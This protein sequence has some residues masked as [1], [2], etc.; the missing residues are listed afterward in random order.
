MEIRTLPLKYKDRKLL[1]ETCV[2]GIKADFLV[3][4]GANASLLPYDIA[5]DAGLL[6][7]LE[8]LPGVC[9]HNVVS[10]YSPTI[11]GRVREP[12]QCQFGL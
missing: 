2:A 3:D 1:L 7:Q 11:H 6:E 8:P 4:T 5:K 12:L 9:L 10:Q